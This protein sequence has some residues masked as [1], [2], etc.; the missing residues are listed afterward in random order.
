MKDDTLYLGHIN[1][2]IEVIEEYLGFANYKQFIANR[3]MVDAGV[4]TM[5]VWE[6]CKNDVP[7][8]KKAVRESLDI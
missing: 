3:M 1:D 6:T 7:T 8:L 2:A 4:D 5:V